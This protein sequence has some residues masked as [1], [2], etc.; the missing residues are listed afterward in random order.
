MYRAKQDGPVVL[1]SRSTLFHSALISLPLVIVL[2]NFIGISY[3]AGDIL[4]KAMTII[5]VA[6]DISFG[7]S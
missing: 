7:M 5:P 2:S 4:G 3:R 1:V 6:M